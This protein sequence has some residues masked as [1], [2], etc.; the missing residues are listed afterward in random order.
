MRNELNET[1][2]KRNE[3]KKSLGE[4]NSNYLREK[5]KVEELKREVEELESQLGNNN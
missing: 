1:I 5:E 3:Y 2:K 4:S